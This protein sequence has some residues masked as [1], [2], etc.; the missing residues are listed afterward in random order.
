MA[1]R[2]GVNGF[3]LPSLSLLGTWF[4][5]LARPTLAS[6][7]LAAALLIVVLLVV[8]LLTAV[9]LAVLFFA[10]VEV[11]R[12][13]GS[14]GDCGTGFASTES[15]ASCAEGAAAWWYW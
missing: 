1:A 13:R 10:L 7:L 9:L 11:G 14:F 15:G 12:K 4:A 2:S 3:G 6:L 8:V 5:C